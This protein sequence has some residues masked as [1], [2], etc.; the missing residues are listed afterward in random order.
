MYIVYFYHERNLLLQQLR[1]KIPADGDEFKIKG[2]K[3]KV[4]QTTIIE[5]NK[6]HVQLQLE[7]VIKKA[8]V[9]LSK[10]KR[11]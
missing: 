9:D 4:V 3:A 5:G 2:R 11:K 1:K 8:A 6:V 7:Q 10:K